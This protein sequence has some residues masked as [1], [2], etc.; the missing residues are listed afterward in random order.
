MKLK[1]F[2]LIFFFSLLN[3]SVFAQWN[4]DRIL[5]I[6]RNALYFEDY[7]LSI[8]YFNQVINIKPYLAEPYMYRA[9]A[10]IQLGDYQ[11]ALLDANESIE[12]NPFVPQAF[13]VRGFALRKLDKF[14]DAANDFSKALE[15]SPDNLNLLMNRM[16]ALERMEDYSGALKDLDKYMKMSPKTYILYYEKGRLQLE[17]KDT[18]AAEKTFNAFVRL[19]STNSVGWSARALLKMQKNDLDGAYYDYTKAIQLNSTYVGDYIN[20]GIVNVQ[21]NRFMEALSDYDYAIKLDNKSDLAYYNRGLLRASLGDNNNALSDLSKVIE[22][23][24]TNMGALYRRAMLENTLGQYRYAIK[25]FK[26]LIDKHPNFQ[27]AYLGVAEAQEG[28]GDKKEGFR[29]RQLAYELE[30]NKDQQKKNKDNIATDN[31]IAGNAPKSTSSRKTEFFNRFIT[32]NV[33]DDQTESKYGDSKRG[34]VQD[35]YADVVNEKNFQLT[36]YAKNDEFRR[37]NLYHPAIDKYNKSKEVVSAL[38]ITNNEIPLTSELVSRHFETINSLSQKITLDP[39]NPDLFFF[40]A[41][42]FALVQDFNSSIDDLNKALSLRND[43]MIAYF[44][45]A[46]IRYKQVEYMKSTNNESVNNTGNLKSNKTK[47]I[48]FE[49]QYKFDIELI[50]RDYDKVIELQPDFGFAYF[51]KANLLTIQGDFKSAISY[52]SKAIELDKDFAEAYFNRGLTNIFI[53]E[54][55]KGK[56]DLS[57]AGELGIYQSYNLIQRLVK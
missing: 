44:C 34:T 32:Q 2:K 16:D 18:L 37:T 48:Q 57:K 54:D 21:Q 3:F 14:Q 23:D 50:M 56:A 8:Q 24:S 7:V 25:D 4:T 10:K 35:K 51:N 55:A 42:E 46:N 15:F 12:R 17:M 13:Y 36:Y 31:K 40:R 52:Y 6:G 53:G 39:N 41:M 28:L 33:D 26:K 1:K 19:D 22:L 20:R 49:D 43:F 9:I 47:K 27:P 5:T 11:G 29:Y 30:K 38:K 45:R